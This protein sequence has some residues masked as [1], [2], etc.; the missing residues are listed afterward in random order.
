MTAGQMEIGKVYKFVYPSNDEYIAKFLR[1]DTYS[2]TGMP[3]DYIFEW[4]SGE[5]TLPKNSGIPGMFFNLT[6]GLLNYVEI[7]K[8]K[9]ND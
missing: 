4:I 5:D 2:A 3:P 8:V 9:E 7:T 6:P 1:I